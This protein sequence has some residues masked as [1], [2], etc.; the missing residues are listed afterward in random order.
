M[1]N[2]DADSPLISPMV[3]LSSYYLIAGNTEYGA[4]IQ[5]LDPM[6]QPVLIDSNAP[7]P[8]GG[9]IRTNV[10]DLL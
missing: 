1:E 4:Y 9:R 7:S 5:K 10:S 2:I 6:R 3:P 8:T